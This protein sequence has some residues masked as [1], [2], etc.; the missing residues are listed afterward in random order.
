MVLDK[1]E[2]LASDKLPSLP[3]VAL[4]VIQL[5][6]N[7]DTEIRKIIHVIKS[8]PALA[9]KL[10]RTANSS[11]F[12][13][14][15]EITTIERAV[16][17]FGYVP[18]SGLVLSFSLLP[19][20]TKEGPIATRLQQFWRSSLTQAVAASELAK[21]AG[22]GM[23]AEYFVAGL[24]QD[25]GALALLR[26]AP[27]EYCRVQEKEE[28]TELPLP[29]IE[30]ELLGVNHIDIGVELL[31]RWGLPK[32]IQHAVAMH[33]AD[34]LELKASCEYG[35]LQRALAS[36][37][38]VADHFFR[39]Q[40]RS[41]N[42]LVYEL[43]RGFYGIENEELETLLRSVIDR[44][45]ETAE[46]FSLDMERYPSY[47][48]ILAAARL[49]LVNVACNAQIDPLTGVESPEVFQKELDR[50]WERA[51]KTGESLGLALFDLDFLDQL[52]Q[53]FGN[54]VGDAA[55]KCVAAE[56]QSLVKAPSLVA[57]FGDDEF[58]VLVPGTVE[59]ELLTIAEQAR[60]AIACHAITSGSQ[61]VGITTSVGVVLCS[62]QAY[63]AGNR[64]HF[65]NV[66]MDMMEEAKR[67]GGNQIRFVPLARDQLAR[68]SHQPLKPEAQAKE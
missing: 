33:H 39:K 34:P 19:S 17:L 1:E 29:L 48:E 45:R 20:S 24:L 35:S 4:K 65:F 41:G 15:C 68:I 25:I 3:A 23:P 27:E 6:S 44:V 59:S 67:T 47:E 8:D 5:A 60:R 31:E 10:L 58:A 38:A 51:M 9:T 21:L 12:R 53:H 30:K 62:P 49:E 66:A 14:G 18:L 40:K 55:L 22:G 7:P 52:N 50:H 46:L 63:P 42:Q 16:P 64:G 37:A 13:L 61:H 26:T 2:I 57:R 11:I 54:P 28:Q 56:L 43:F 36:S 32:R